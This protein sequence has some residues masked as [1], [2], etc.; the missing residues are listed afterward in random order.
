[1]EWHKSHGP[2]G[3]VKDEKLTEMEK[4]KAGYDFLEI[5]RELLHDLDKHLKDNK[6]EFLTPIP[7]WDPADPIPL[8]IS[9][10]GKI[11]PEICG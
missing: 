10:P 9:L 6:A 2:G 5:H 7:Y 3:I 11:P 1:M 4:E 8:E